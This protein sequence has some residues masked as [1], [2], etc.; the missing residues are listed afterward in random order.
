MFF[1]SPLRHHLA[2]SLPYVQVMVPLP[3]FFFPLACSMRS[4]EIYSCIYRMNANPGTFYKNRELP[5]YM[6]EDAQKDFFVSYN[7]ADRAWAEWI[8]W[9]LEAESYTTILQAWDFRPGSNFVLEMQS[10]TSRA[11][12]TIAV[13]S[14][15][16]LTSM[17]TQPEWAAAFVQDPTGQKGFLLPV[18]VRPCQLTGL[19]SSII[20]LDLVDLD[21]SEATAALLAGVRQTRAKPSRA[22]SFPGRS[23]QLASPP[24]QFPGSL[25]PIRKSLAKPKVQQEPTN[26]ISPEGLSQAVVSRSPMA[27]RDQESQSGR[28]VKPTKQRKRRLLVAHVILLVLLFS[29]LPFLL[30][31]AH[32]ATFSRSSQQQTKPSSTK[33]DGEVQDQNLDVQFIDT[34]QNTFALPGDPRGL[35][36]NQLSKQGV[37]ALSIDQ[38]K[39]QVPTVFRIAIR[40]SNL[41]RDQYVL[42]IEQVQ[43]IVEQITSIPHPL[44]ALV[45]NPPAL[46]NY[47]LYRGTYTG[48]DTNVPI[49]TTYDNPP[50]T[51]VFLTLHETDTINIQVTSLVEALLS[52]RIAIT[53]RVA[54][55]DQTHTLTLPHIFQVVFSDKSNWHPYQLRDGH[56][57]QLDTP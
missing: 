25:P 10:A 29:L 45:Q 14:P 30:P 41:R 56:F 4:K 37:P 3:A 22:P 35:S 12:R 53:Y 40:I 24:P 38:P 2:H 1:V 50:Y 19:L 7:K 57:T 42:L 8:A 17:Y 28:S 31:S 43:F 34:Q 32:F 11:K 20:Y 21:A 16:Y 26:V 46:S 48:Q 33:N 5:S 18:R 51:Y 44:Y 39:Q 47:N 27:V 54:N 15:E 13:L 52:F 6:T 9:Q 23:P 49:L 55:E 36:P